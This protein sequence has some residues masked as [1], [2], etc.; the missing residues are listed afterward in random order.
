MCRQ[1]RNKQI[2]FDPAWGVSETVGFPKLKSWTEHSNPDIKYYSGTAIYR[3]TFTLG[4]DEIKN[5]RIRLHLGE[6][7]NLAEI[8]VNGRSA[9]VWWKNPFAG[10]ITSLVQPGENALEIAV[11]NLWVNR[12]IGDQFLPEDRRRTNTNVVKFTKESTLLP[13]GLVGPVYLSFGTK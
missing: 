5:F 3:K 2:S 8:R 11:V 13:S 6:L 4:E 1:P 10:D 7:Y 9:G 12:L